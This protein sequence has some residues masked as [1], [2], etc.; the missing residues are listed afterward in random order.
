MKIDHSLENVEGSTV[1]NSKSKKNFLISKHAN[2]KDVMYKNVFRSFK[3]F[4]TTQFK[5][6]SDFFS[7]T[8]IKDKKRLAEDHLVDFVTN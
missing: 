5:N 6:H 1:D 3:R 7:I 4:F 2:R 8:A